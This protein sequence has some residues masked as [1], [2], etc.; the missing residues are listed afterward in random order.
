MKVGI[1]VTSLVKVSPI[2]GTIELGVWL[3][4]WWKD[5]R[6]AYSHFNNSVSTISFSHKE[7][8]ALLGWYALLQS[9][10]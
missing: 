1:A 3:R 9:V 6:L 5:E 4:S 10:M 8:G 7:V 2:E